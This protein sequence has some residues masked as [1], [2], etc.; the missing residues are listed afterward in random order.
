[1]TWPTRELPSEMTTS[2]SPALPSS[3][4][5]AGAPPASRGRGVALIVLLVGAGLGVSSVLYRGIASD[6]ADNAAAAKGSLPRTPEGRVE[7]WL[8]FVGPGMHNALKMLRISAEQPWIVTHTTGS[9]RN[10]A[11]QE[12]WG[13]DFDAL[14]PALATQQGLDVV[15]ELPPPRN[16]G[17]GAITGDKVRHVPHVAPGAP[18]FDAA[19]RAV[20]VVEHVLDPITSKLAEDIEGAR[21]FVRIRPE[22]AAE[23]GDG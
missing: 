19:A 1:M 12:V 22:A 11:D 6:L 21:F 14:P 16:L 23:P 2:T 4:A 18:P 8:E 9:A 20:Q 10:A 7:R 17:P 15:V 5:P 3:D 13:I